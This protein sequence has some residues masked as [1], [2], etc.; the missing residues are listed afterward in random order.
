MDDRMRL[1]RALLMLRVREMERHSA[2]A[3]LSRALDDTRR[4]QDLAARTRSLAEAF[5]VRRDAT[6][7]HALHSQLA[8]T[9]QTHTLCRHAEQA[10]G[11]CED[12]LDALRQAERGARLRQD[13]AA[14]RH[15]EVAAAI[16]RDRAAREASA[17]ISQACR[18]QR[19]LARNLKRV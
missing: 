16:S 18:R 17:D 15:G 1:H 4:A 8:L 2:A 14:E 11:R 10:A 6:L 13:R 19:G 5:A 9:R 7:G 3:A 12:D